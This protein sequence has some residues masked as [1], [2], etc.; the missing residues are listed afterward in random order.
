VVWG[1]GGG[2]QDARPHPHRQQHRQEGAPAELRLARRRNAIGAREGGREL[3]EWEL[4]TGPLATGSKE[5][6]AL[7]SGGMV[8]KGERKTV[9]PATPGAWLPTFNETPSVQYATFG[10]TDDRRL[11]LRY[12]SRFGSSDTVQRRAERFKVRQI[13][14]GAASTPGAWLP[15]Y[16]A[17][18]SVLYATFGTTES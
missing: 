5:R 18:R 16:N 4:A 12:S 2:N 7:G 17:T 14:E 6:K 1:S 11:L 10:T 15:T 9:L 13:I 8:E 3:A